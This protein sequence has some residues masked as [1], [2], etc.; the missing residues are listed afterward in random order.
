MESILHSPLLET[1][2]QQAILSTSLGGLGLR[3][4]ALHAPAAY[5][6][7]VLA[8]SKLDGWNPTNAEDF[9]TT[10]MMLRERTK[11]N[12]FESMQDFPDVSQS[13]FSSR[14]DTSQWNTIMQISGEADCSR[15][16]SC[17]SSG[18]PSAWLNAV[19]SPFAGAAFSPRIFVIAVK[20]WL[21]AQIQTTTANC[22]FCKKRMDDK[23]YHACTCRN[24]GTFT[25]R[26]N[27][28]VHVI[29]AFC[30]QGF[31][32]PKLE[33]CIPTIQTRNGITRE[34]NTRGDI[35]LQMH[36]TTRPRAMDVAVT[37]PLQPM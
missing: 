28:L 6:S 36:S 11:E 14:I 31:L 25:R 33:P 22:P 18:L 2:W 4:S 34:Y 26:H 10:L 16:R 27:K 32:A 23:G 30:K 8:C 1:Q 5:I 3:S 35:I 17:S 15:I 24:K 29:L 37:S 20:L 19:P 9:H 7:S 12:L 21:G 13:D